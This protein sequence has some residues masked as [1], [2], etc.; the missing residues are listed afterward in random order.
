M[1][2]AE[3]TRPVA[4]L[5]DSSLGERIDQVLALAMVLAAE[6]RREIRL[7]SLSV[8]RSSLGLAA[9]AELMVR[10]YR[11]ER[12]GAPP[13][14][15]SVPVG[16]FDGEPPATVEPMIAS[17]VGRT[18]PGGTPL[19]PRSI[20][21]LNQ[22]ADPVAVVRNALSA[23]Q[24]QTA[25]VVLAG[26]PV[27]LLGLLALPEGPGLV[28]RKVRTLVAT[29]LAP[30]TSGLVGRW[31]GPVVLAGDDLDL[32]YPAA[33]IEED[34]AWTPDH[35]V[36]DAWR[37]AG[38]MPYDAPAAAM[39]AALHAVAPDEGYF[40]LAG[41]AGGYRRL[42]AGAEQRD[43]AVRAMRELVSTEPRAGGPP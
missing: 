38:P 15:T 11:G 2:N 42:T 24:D 25:V 35:P 10:F 13:G 1:Q 20:E 43:R 5:F 21:R 26:P 3:R 40:G 36:V 6:S 8:S 31:P 33:S 19:Y 16:M 22:T 39:A 41:V 27:N 23:Q 4:V 32:R 30:G 7:G 12:P 18:G 9:F 14:R 17:V 37:A 29:D 34:F 28:A